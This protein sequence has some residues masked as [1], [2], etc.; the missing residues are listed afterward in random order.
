MTKEKNMAERRKVYHV[1]LCSFSALQSC[2]QKWNRV[3]ASS[4]LCLHLLLFPTSTISLAFSLLPLF[5]SFILLLY[6]PFS[7]LWSHLSSSCHISSPF[8]F[9]FPSYLY[10]HSPIFVC[11][12]LC[13]SSSLSLPLSNPVFNSLTLPSALFPSYPSLCQSFL[14]LSLLFLPTVSSPLLL[15]CCI[16]QIFNFFSCRHQLEISIGGQSKVNGQ[17]KSAIYPDL[18]SN[19]W[20]MPIQDDGVGLMGLGRADERKEMQGVRK[21]EDIL[22]LSLSS[23]CLSFGLCAF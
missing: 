7:T 9:R 10:F 23:R 3:F 4:F 20:V 8:L 5:L 16:I 6:T 12:P 1:I 11:L 21:S 22:S 17:S 19:I 13:S 14:Y 15:A 2:C 18:L